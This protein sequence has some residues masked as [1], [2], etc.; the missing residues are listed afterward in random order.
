MAEYKFEE[1]MKV[2]PKCESKKIHW[3]NHE[4]SRIWECKN[5]NYTGPVI[6][7]KNKNDLSN[8]KIIRKL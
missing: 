6:I 5:C 4:D 3:F 8:I 1:N 7:E 2:C